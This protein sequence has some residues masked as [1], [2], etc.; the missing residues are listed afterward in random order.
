MS[1]PPSST[2]AAAALKNNNANQERWAQERNQNAIFNSLL[3]AKMAPL[4]LVLVVLHQEV[5]ADAFGRR[6]REGERGCRRELLRPRGGQSLGAH[7]ERPWVGF[8]VPCND[9]D[10]QLFRASTRVTLGDGKK[11]QFWNSSWLECWMVMHPEIWHPAFSGL[12]GGKIIL[13]Q[14]IYKT[15][16]GPEVYGE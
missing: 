13:L 3:Q 11:A 15:Q 6:R 14:M 16:T 7:A 9:A 4:V 2:P 5:E 12:L 8:D 1:S 10:R